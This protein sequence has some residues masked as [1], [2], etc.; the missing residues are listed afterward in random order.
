MRGNGK[1]FSSVSLKFVMRC[2]CTDKRFPHF[3]YN[4]ASNSGDSFCYVAERDNVVI[5]SLA[6]S[7]VYREVINELNPNLSIVAKIT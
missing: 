4:F 5:V 3:L 7:R 2:T 6:E 1:P